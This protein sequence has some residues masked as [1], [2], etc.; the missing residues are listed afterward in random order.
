MKI[1]KYA[2]YD[3]FQCLAQHCP[4][5]CC[6]EWDVLVDDESARQYRALTGPLGDRLRQVL[7]EDEDGNTYMSIE[8][9]RCPMWQED[10]LCRIQSELGHDALCQTCRDFPRLTHD[11]GDFVEYQLELSCPEAA[12]LL[13]TS[14]EE[15]P[16]VITLPGCPEVEYDRDAMDILLKSRKEILSILQMPRP[17]EE[18]LAIALFYGYHVQ[19]QLYGAAADHFDPEA[20]LADGKALAVP[21]D[22]ASIAAF[23]STLEILTPQWKQRL[24]HTYPGEWSA[25]MLALFRYGVERY[26][27]QAVSDRDLI[28]R[29]KMILL[30]C[31]LVKHLGGDPVET[32]QLYS[33]EIENSTENVEDI[34]DGVFVDPALQDDRLLGLLLLA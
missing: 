23:F 24:A 16:V 4:D 9:R 27:L 15:P 11:Y 19:A 22:P 26:W 33:K 34:L 20:A 30:S 8:N 25:P 21:A 18:I 14:P 13:L 6:K 3:R 12:R 1:I 32:A 28:A 5:S 2:G 29:V 17:T 10:G 7:R 31:L